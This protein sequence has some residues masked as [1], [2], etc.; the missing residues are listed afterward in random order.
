MRKL[1]W[2]T[3]TIATLVTSLFLF[4][5][6]HAAT[7]VT[8]QIN[9]DTTWTFAN[10]PYRLTGTVFVSP[11]VTLTIEPGVTIDF[12]MFSLQI[13]G[14][15]LIAQGTNDNKII[16]YSSYIY[17]SISIILSSGT[18]WND[19]T[20]TGSIIENAVLNSAYISIA[21]CSPKISNNYFTN[22][23]Y[24][25]LSIVNGSSLILNNSFD[26]QSTS[27]YVSST[28]PC[29][30][31][32]FDNFVKC[33]SI[34]AYGINVGSNNAYI[35][36]NNV[37]G[38]YMGVYAT[39][40]ATVTRNLIRN[41]TYGIYLG[42]NSANTASVTSNIVANNSIGIS[43]GGGIIMDNTIGN[44]QIGL[45]VSTTSANIS[46]NN[47]FANTQY[48]LGISTVNAVDAR[49]NWWGIADSSV[50]NQTIYDNKNST[51]LGKVSFTPFLNDSNT[52]APAIESINFVPNPTP[53]AIPTPVP[54]PT[55]TYTPI[56][57]NITFG[58][59][60]TETPPPTLPTSE[61]TPI[62]TPTPMP[63]PTPT[64]KVIPGSPLSM[65]GQSLAEAISQFDLMG[66]A[67]LV[68]IILGVMWTVVILVYVNKTVGKKKKA[69]T[70]L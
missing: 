42:S 17:S 20:G 9:S 54:A 12:N 36:A 68:L 69:S 29:S 55:Q 32:I 18:S 19:T 28:V 10:S 41:N 16:F 43:I 45:S 70:G 4:A 67:Q 40:N 26:T 57:T 31:K 38:C 64:Q 25:S 50:I 37:T 58:P 15:T 48:N 27:I 33:T 34:T 35:S 52:A 2:L 39:G 53:T 1:I 56:P 49:Y 14:G 5:N 23:R 59:I 11:G 30:P 21:S 47:I 65:G 66:V 22:N 13:N 46:Q 51:S 61:P 3:L 6:V 7:S 24:T 44:N 60:S 8:G 62:P 63:T